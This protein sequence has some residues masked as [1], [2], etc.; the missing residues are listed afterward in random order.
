MSGYTVDLATD[1]AE[2]IARTGLCMT[3]N[4]AGSCAFLANAAGPIW[5]CEEFDDRDPGEVRPLRLVRDDVP[6]S[7]AADDGAA[8]AQLGLCANCDDRNG[9]ALRVPG[10]PVWHCEE[11]R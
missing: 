2:T 8:A 3:C 4:L 7:T 11:Y 6:T 9:C 10:Q 1:G 5:H